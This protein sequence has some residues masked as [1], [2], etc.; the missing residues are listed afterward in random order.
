MSKILDEMEKTASA[1]RIEDLERIEQILDRFLDM[2]LEELVGDDKRFTFL[3]RDIAQGIILEQ[4]K[5]EEL[6]LRDVLTLIG[7]EPGFPWFELPEEDTWFYDNEPSRKFFSAGHCFFLARI[8]KDRASYDSVLKQFM[9]MDYWKFIKYLSDR[10]VEKT[11]EQTGNSRVICQK[12]MKLNRLYRITDR[13][14]REYSSV[15]GDISVGDVINTAC[16][17]GLRCWICGTEPLN[18]FMEKT[19]SAYNT[20]RILFMDCMRMSLIK[21]DRDSFR[22]LLDTCSESGLYDEDCYSEIDFNDCYE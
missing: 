13:F 4:K 3:G 18:I 15:E 20:M 8:I 22:L 16:S 14:T 10:M 17:I 7:Y 2:S 19:Q 11:G 21:S 12:G 9:Y 1:E 6:S 5:V